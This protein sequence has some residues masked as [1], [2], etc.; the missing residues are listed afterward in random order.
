MTNKIVVLGF[1]RIG[2]KR[3][4]KTALEN[5]W[6]GNIPLNEL[7]S[8]AS[9]LR[10]KHWILQRNAGIETVAVNDFSFYDNTLDL[11]LALGAEP[12]RF[13]DITN[14][15][16][17]YFTMARGD[18]THTAMEMTKWFNTNYHYIVPELTIAFE[19]GEI[20]ADK[21]VNEYREAR[22]N[23]FQ[24][25]I[26]LIGPITFLGLS[27][28]DKDV[29]LSLF[30]SLLGQY[31]KLLG[32]IIAFDENVEIVMHEPFLSTGVDVQQLSLLKI[33]YERLG[34]VSKTLSVATYF[35]HSNEATAVLV[36]TPIKGLVFDF[37]HG[38]KNSE[39]L[40]ILGKSDKHVTIGIIDG[41]NVWKNNLQQSLKTLEHIETYIPKERLTIGASCSLLHVPYTL[42]HEENLDAN[43]KELLAFAQEKLDELS[44]LGKAFFS[45]TKITFPSHPKATADEAVQTRL[46]T[47]KPNDFKR[48]H[49]FVVRQMSAR[50]TF[51]LPPLPTTTIGSFPQTAEVRKVRQEFKKGLITKEAYNETM[52]KMIASCVAFQES[53]DLDVLVHGEF[54][55]ND[56]VEYFGEQLN[57]F[58]FSQN[59]WVQ[60]YGSRC[61][62]PPLLYG[63]VSRPHPMTLEWSLYAQSLTHRPM[64]GMLTGPVTILNWS[65][66]RDDQ[67]RST[68]AMQIA[69]AI[70]DEVDDLQRAG[71]AMIQVDEAA[72]KEGYPLRRENR[73][74]YEKWALD[75]F[76][77]STAVAHK[78]TQIHTHMCYS[79]FTDIIKTI[80]AMDADVIS[81]ETSRSGNRLLQIFKETG[82]AQE[83]GPGVYD[84]HSPRIPSV[85]EMEQ[86]IHAL[87]KVLPASQLWINPD[88]GLKTRG[89]SESEAALKNMVEATKAVRETL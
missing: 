62:K 64:K 53:I 66:V 45:H 29:T 81:I 60:S 58:A 35:E 1:P 79:E 18:E 24:G 54:E 15:T 20:C 31:S 83:V 85:E 55:R 19:F 22:E 69:L 48:S 5:Y 76:L 80:E 23:G 46:S 4:L 13:R 50:D 65:F 7:E 21:I 42:K 41:R 40:E 33:V 26:Q 61:V 37:V 84:I 36:H 49:P 11:M 74:T 82:Y 52:K 57:G 17:R 87:L 32:E 89:W 3:E 8:V 56:M 68:T 47:L 59:G 72:F 38:V 70:R 77:L 67:P 43:I 39:S 71:I 30:D 63:D 44:V 86:Q 12:E 75:S 10:L 16:Q 14:A 27:R 25:S 2:E 51:D 28:C 6:K 34:R 9:E 78:E 73:S 88:C